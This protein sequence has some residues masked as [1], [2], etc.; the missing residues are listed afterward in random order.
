MNP[1]QTSPTPRRKL[2]DRLLAILVVL[3]GLLVLKVAEPV[4]LPLTFAI[5]LVAV[6]WPLQRRLQRRLPA[7]L[8]ALTT[9]LV[10]LAVLALLVGAL[11]FAVDRVV[12]HG[13]PYFQEIEDL[14]HGARAWLEARGVPVAADDGSDELRTRLASLFGGTLAVV[15]SFVLV[16][17]LFVL[18]LLEVVDYREKLRVAHGGEP[19]AWLA[20]LHR[21]TDDFQRY[22]VVRTLAG[23]ITGV[24][25]W[26]VCLLAGLDF[27]LM[28]GL[29]NFLL[30][31]IPTVGSIVG[32]I[33]PVLFA[34]VQFDDPGRALLVLGGV[35]GVQLLMGNYVDP[36]LQ[37]RFLRLSP[38]VVLLSVI[39]W[40]WLWGIGG[41]F[42]SMPIT[43]AIVIATRQSPRTRWIA[44]I[45]ADVQESRRGDR[46]DG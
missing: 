28:W 31:Y 26:L 30:N 15:S 6:F 46:D 33:P 45:L 14:M 37:G 43:V 41:A 9:L 1:D 20:A 42:L 40:G 19:E 12:D 8:A 36:L 22:I 3:A 25:T 18:A 29:I 7:A 4:L 32:V 38:F 5:F 34:L 35:G 27:A 16:L 44:T 17:A 2:T 11:V 24:A 21:V 10:F 39:F 13:A 23:L